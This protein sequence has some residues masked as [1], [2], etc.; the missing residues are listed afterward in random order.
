MTTTYPYVRPDAPPPALAPRGRSG[1]RRALQGPVGGNPTWSVLQCSRCLRNCAA[2]PD[3]SRRL[4]GTPTSLC[5]RCAGRHEE[6]EGDPLR[7]AGLG[8]NFITVDKPGFVVADGDRRPH[9]RIQF[10]VNARPTGPDGALLAVGLLALTVKRWFGPAA[11]LIAGALA[12]GDSGRRADVPL[13]QPR[14]VDDAAPRRR[15]LRGYPGHRRRQA[16]WLVVAGAAMGFDFLT[17]SLQPFPV[18]PALAIVYLVT[19][20]T[21]L[22]RRI[23]NLLLAGAAMV[24]SGGWWVLAVTFDPREQPALYRWLGQQLRVGAGLGLQR[25][26]PADGRRGRHTWRQSGRWR[27]RADRSASRNRGRRSRCRRWS[28]W[29]RRWRLRRLVR[30]RPDVQLRLRH[31]DLWLLPAALVAVVAAV[32]RRP[33]GAANRPDP[34]RS[35][36]VGRLAPRNRRSIQLRERH[37]PPVLRGATRSGH[38]CAGRDR[39]RRARGGDV[40]LWG[41]G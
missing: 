41:P 19:A 16:G 7:L 26:Q 14:R 32:R 36:A 18:L 15:C 17:K 37:H 29:W 23:R 27:H 40:R 8:G 38:R 34:C 4:F 12:C 5:G 1:V 3:E 39:R 2:I 31:A 24:V 22:G 11:G 13:Q 35:T 20:N 9:L 30:A 21:T 25:A 10:L 28:R 33:P 6:L